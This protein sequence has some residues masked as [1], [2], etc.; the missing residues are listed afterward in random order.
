MRRAIAFVLLAGVVAAAWVLRPLL[1][2]AERGRRLAERTGCFG[3]HG[4]EGTRGAGNP[5]RNDRTV[6]NFEDD[7]MMYADSPQQI[8]EWIRD[9]VSAKKAKS[10]TWRK[11]RALGALKMPAFKRR[12]TASQIDDLVAF[13]QAMS[14]VPDPTDSLA[15]HGAE[16]AKALGCFGCHGPGGRLARPNPGSFKGYVPSWDGDDF[17]TLVRDRSEFDQWVEHGV[18]ARFEH[19]R[20]ARYFLDRATMR[21]PAYKDHLEPGDLDALWAC[22]QWT[23]GSSTPRRNP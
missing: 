4:P 18:N 7:V 8:R 16:R 12:L 13:V 15:A 3:C 19:D 17:P 20:L 2:A 6:P 5:G 14:T 23:R 10:E 9:G 22:V 1:P 11:Q 21:M